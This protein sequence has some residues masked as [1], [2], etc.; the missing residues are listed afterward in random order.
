[1]PTKVSFRDFSSLARGIDVQKLS[2]VM[3]IFVPETDETK[4]RTAWFGTGNPDA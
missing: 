1:M 3:F 2:V 4:F